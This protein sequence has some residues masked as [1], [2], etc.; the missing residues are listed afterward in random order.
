MKLMRYG[1]AGREKPAVLDASGKIRD[2]SSLVSDYDP[3]TLGDD[4]VSRLRQVEEQPEVTG[5]PRIG[6]VLA[7]VGTI[8]CIGLNYVDHAKEAGM[9]VPTEPVVF[10]KAA[11]TVCGPNDSIPI[12]A[13]MAKLD[14]E[15]ELG[16]VIGR[17]AFRVTEAQALEHVFGYTVVNDVSERAWQLERGGQW[18]KGKSHPNFCPLGP[19]LVTG[20]EIPDLQSLQL[21]LDVNAVPKQRGSTSSM[22]FPVAKLVSYLSQFARLEPGDLICTGTP[23]GVGAGMKPPQFLR[24]GDVVTLG[25]ELLGKQK[26]RVESA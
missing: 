4:L 5:T 9:A 24:S 15:V 6:P 19:W 26:Q 20:D 7:R 8:W 23:P 22:I 21:W 25:I 3:S 17:R 11:S 14:W 1:E 2:V 13:A 16:V 12:T 18:M 10:S